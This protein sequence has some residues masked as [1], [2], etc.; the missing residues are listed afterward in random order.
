MCLLIIFFININHFQG[1]I[2]ILLICNIN[3]FQS[4]IVILLI[5]SIY[6]YNNNPLMCPLLIIF[7]QFD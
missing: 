6:S 7:D 4:L 5:C 2:V 1:L 3:H